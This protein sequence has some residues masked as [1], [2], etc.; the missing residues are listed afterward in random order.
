MSVNDWKRSRSSASANAKCSGSEV[1]SRIA[2]VDDQAA[3]RVVSRRSRSWS[4][5]SRVKLPFERG[6]D[7]F[8]AA[9]EVEQLLLERVEVGEVVGGEELALG[10]AEVDLGL[11]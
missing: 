3:M 5:S 1:R 8:V 9:A 10:D 7:L 2:V 4:R 11:V 6:G